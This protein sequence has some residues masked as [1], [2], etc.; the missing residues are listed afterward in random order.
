MKSN[1]IKQ[2]WE[3][4]YA[5]KDTTK[6]V[7]WYQ[8]DPRTSIELIL[9]TGVGKSG[10]IIDIGGGDSKLVDKLLE[11]DFKNLFVLDISGQAIKKAK[12]RLGNKAGSVTW[13][14]SD[15]LEFEINIHF[16]V[17]HDRAAFHFLTKSEDIAKYVETAGQYIKPGGH[18]IISAFSINGPK[19]CSGLDITQYSEDSIK[20]TFGEK[21]NHIKSFEQ[22]HTT[23]FNTKQNFLWSVF[24]RSK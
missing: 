14:E 8:D 2:H 22:V 10:N 16:D 12:E 3:A 13:I 7:S 1:F 11:R 17:W 24:Q 15:V 20:R 9:A 21:F 23:P 4:I 18:L 6:E 5:G 19:R